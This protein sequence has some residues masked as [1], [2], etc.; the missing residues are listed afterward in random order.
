MYREISLPL[1]FGE[2]VAH[3]TDAQ[4]VIVNGLNLLVTGFDVGFHLVAVT[5]VTN[6]VV[7]AVR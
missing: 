4:V 3:D 6:R 7:Q 1:R 2:Y 5:R